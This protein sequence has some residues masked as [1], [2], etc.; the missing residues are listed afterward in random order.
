MI[1]LGELL[2]VINLDGPSIGVYIDTSPYM[3]RRIDEE[4]LPDYYDR[5]VMQ[6]LFDTTEID[7]ENYQ[8]DFLVEVKIA[9]PMLEDDKKW[10]RQH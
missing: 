10:K 1:R 2:K 4:K 9:G 7:Y 5:E 8:A 3:A 6:I